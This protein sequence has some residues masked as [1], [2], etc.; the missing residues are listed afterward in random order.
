[1]R[2]N[3]EV[4]RL[5]G[6]ALDDFCAER[7]VLAKRLRAQGEGEAA[8]AVLA[9]RKPT[10]AAWLVNQVVRAEPKLLKELLR[11]GAGLREAQARVLAGEGAET[12]RHAVGAERAAVESLVA[13]ACGF[14][15]AGRLASR[16]VLARV[17][18][19]FYAV[20]RDDEVRERV[21][22][23]LMERETVASGWPER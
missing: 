5:Y 2:L 18:D 19:T 10:Y 7:D 20:A 6:L 9:L 12:L 21:K 15:P 3:D 13:A 22:A 23:G 1:M 14:L 4:G 8:A 16:A 17:R 11:A